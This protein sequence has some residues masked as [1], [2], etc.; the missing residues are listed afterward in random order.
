VFGKPKTNAWEEAYDGD[1]GWQAEF[2]KRDG[3]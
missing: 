1:F 3:G 2:T